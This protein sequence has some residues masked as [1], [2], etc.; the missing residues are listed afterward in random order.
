MH[1]VRDGVKEGGFGL[2]TYMMELTHY[3]SYLISNQVGMPRVYWNDTHGEELVLDGI[4]ITMTSFSLFYQALF[5][6]T[7]KIL[8]DEV[9]LGLPIPPGLQVEHITDCLSDCSVGYSFISDPRNSFT[10]FRKVL[11]DHILSPIHKDRYLFH[12]LFIQGKSPPWNRGKGGI[13]SWLK[14][15]ERCIGNLFALL[16]Y[17]SQPARGT[18]LSTLKWL[19]TVDQRRSVYWFQGFI[20]IITMYNKTQTNS[21]RPRAICRSLPPNVGKLFIVWMALVIP[22]LDS[23]WNDL[24]TG[25]DPSLRTVFS[26]NLFASRYGKLDTDDFSAILASKSGRPV[27]DGGLGFPM[28][29]S[30]T[31]HFLIAIMRE[32]IKR[33]P[34]V[35]RSYLEEYFNEQ[36]GHGE[37]AA[38]HYALPYTSISGVSSEKLSGFVEL[39]KLHHGLLSRS[40]N[41]AAVT[42][43]PTTAP[44]AVSPKISNSIDY[45]LL[46]SS[47]LKTTFQSQ[48][49]TYLGPGIHKTIM[50][51]FSVLVPQAQGLNPQSESNPS[52]SSTTNA[53]VSSEPL[54]VDV[55]NVDVSGRRWDELRRMIGN[56]A[57]F[58]SAFQACAVEL[59]ARREND[60][61]II[62]GTGEGKSLTFMLNAFREEEKGMVTIVIVP[63]LALQ[64]DLKRRMREM[65]I[66]V[67]C[68]TTQ[69]ADCDVDNSI[70]V[71]LVITDTA[72]NP[73]FTHISA[74]RIDP[75]LQNKE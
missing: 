12:G 61:F 67:M 5:S 60:L 65:K 26:Q 43:S 59:C 16:H 1:T 62:M 54:H 53:S 36:S 66:G 40:T 69:D 15:S 3:L 51:S 2:F 27:V 46:A 74:H 41:S 25:S 31:R 38:E 19:N 47:M 9:L 56:H 22:A 63:L 32:H 24:T 50:E 70:Q 55:L 42:V 44:A 13:D 39:S 37:D 8:H 14:S 75:T 71:V 4:S 23:I 72:A 11:L 57:S 33:L 18:E 6:E 52:P 48:L 35:T 73:K 10:T 28:T 58:K 68:W 45:N 64:D 49:A 29:I 30:V 21:E 34:S 17:G 20:N 7:E